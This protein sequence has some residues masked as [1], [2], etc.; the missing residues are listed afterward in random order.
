MPAAPIAPPDV[1]AARAEQRLAPD[2]GL[3]SADALARLGGHAPL[4]QHALRSFRGEMD[5][6][7]PRLAEAAAA[8]DATKAAGTLHLM[9]GLAGMIGAERLAAAALAAESE[10]MPDVGEMPSWGRVA[11]VSG[12]VAA[13]CALADAAVGGFGGGEEVLN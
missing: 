13:A 6:L 9:R 10:L 3:N 2:A 1:L 5:K 11:Q 7:M 8:G 12:E 4:Y